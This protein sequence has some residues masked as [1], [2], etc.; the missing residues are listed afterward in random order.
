[1]NLINQYAASAHETGAQPIYLSCT[2]EDLIRVEMEAWERGFNQAEIDAFGA[3]EDIA[4]IERAAEQVC[5]QSLD[6]YVPLD[7][8]RFR[9]VFTRAWCAGYCATVGRR[10]DST[11]AP[12]SVS[13]VPSASS[14]QSR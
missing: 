4:A 10:R 3:Q 9:D 2:A 13:I 6:R 1:M 14:P 12:T 5:Y 8:D 7:L 11:R